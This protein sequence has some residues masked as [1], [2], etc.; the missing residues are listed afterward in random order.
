VDELL[1]EK[2]QIEQ[3]RDWWKENGTYVIAGIVLG[4]GGIVGFNVWKGSQTNTRVEASNRYEEL[5]EEVAENRLDAAETIAAD[6]SSQYAGTIYADQAHL[7]M[8]R[9]YMDQGRDQDAA[10]ELQTLIDAGNSDE[11]KM[12][13]RLRLAKV[14]LYQGKPE[15]VLTLLSGYDDSGFASRYAEALGD[16]QYALGNYAEAEAAYARALDDPRAAQLMDTALIQ[17]KINDIPDVL[18]E[19]VSASPATSGVTE[20]TPEQDAATDED[21]NAEPEA[22]ADE[23]AGEPIE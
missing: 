7:A 10:E 3:I 4:V 11:M 15:D 23:S 1:S 18:P 21:A 5:A 19:G 6:I 16:A 2:E 12:I 17:M 22:P 8:A 9:L 13:A 14:L 20:S